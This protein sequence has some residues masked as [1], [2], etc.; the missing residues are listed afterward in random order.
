MNP[1]ALYVKPNCPN[2]EAVKPLLSELAQAVGL[3]ERDIEIVD[4]ES[5]EGRKRIEASGLAANG[6]LTLPALVYSAGF[7]GWYT[8]AALL[9]IDADCENGACSLGDYE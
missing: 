6:G 7:L 4:A 2:C 8:L 3:Q 1:V 5:P 9:G